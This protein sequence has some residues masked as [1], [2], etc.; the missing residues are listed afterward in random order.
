MITLIFKDGNLRASNQVN[1]LA[2]PHFAQTGLDLIP[3]SSP[4]LAKSCLLPALLYVMGFK[5]RLKKK[6]SKD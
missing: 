3:L 1:K 6:F 2:L 5:E 4:A